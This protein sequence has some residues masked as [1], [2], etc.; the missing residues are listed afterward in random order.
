MN[1]TICTSAV[2][3]WFGVTQ[4]VHYLHSIEDMVRALRKGGFTARSRAGKFAGK[5]LG[6]VRDKLAKEAE[7]L[8]PFHVYGFVVV[9]PGHALLVN[10]FGETII[11]T[12][13]RQ[14]D[15]RKIQQIYVIY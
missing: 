15:R 7:S 1:K 13:S 9:V 14:K 3:D 12:A 10:R 8:A 6:S 4:N 5:S 11:D 2:T